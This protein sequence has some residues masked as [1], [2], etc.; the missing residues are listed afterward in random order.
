MFCAPPSVPSSFRNKLHSG[1]CCVPRLWWQSASEGSSMRCWSPCSMSSPSAPPRQPT[2]YWIRSSPLK[3]L[4]C[5]LTD[6]PAR[7]P[8]ST[9]HAGAGGA[10][11]LPARAGRTPE[12][13]GVLDL[14]DPPGIAGWSRHSGAGPCLTQ[15]CN[16]DR[17][18]LGLIRGE[19]H[20][21]FGA[22]SDHHPR[23]SHCALARARPNAP[24]PALLA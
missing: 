16:P 22:A 9:E 20:F 4:R 17:V 13:R 24:R 6:V 8:R 7:P 21:A 23:H 2:S 10:L 1:T 12:V 15:S 18:G 5:C 3:R 19:P 14:A 11:L